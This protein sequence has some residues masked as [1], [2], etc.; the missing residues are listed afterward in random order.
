MSQKATAVFC[1]ALSSFPS[2][3]LLNAGYEQTTAPQPSSSI[4]NTWTDSS[5][6][7]SCMNASSLV[8]SKTTELES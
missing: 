3:C 7:S 4:T 1:K 5:S 8:F 2:A 6:K